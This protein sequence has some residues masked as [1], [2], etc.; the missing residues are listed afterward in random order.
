MNHDETK[1]TVEK[2]E[3]ALAYVVVAVFQNRIAVHRSGDL[4]QQLL[5]TSV[6][7]V[8]IKETIKKLMEQGNGKN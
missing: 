1:K 8:Q 3:D 7:D 4:Q 2:I 6:V 5:A